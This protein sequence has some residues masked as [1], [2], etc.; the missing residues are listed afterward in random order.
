MRACASF[1]FC[2]PISPLL[3][4][5]VSISLQYPLYAYVVSS[6]RVFLPLK[7]TTYEL[8]R[9]KLLFLLAKCWSVLAY[10]LFLYVNSFTA[11]TLGHVRLHAAL[12]RP[13]NTT[14]CD[15]IP[16]RG[17]YYMR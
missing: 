11:Y 9:R 7:T 15:S 2:I 16:S 10:I 4:H 5:F 8:R 17:C 12:F 14:T 13:W 3:L 6:V 1:R